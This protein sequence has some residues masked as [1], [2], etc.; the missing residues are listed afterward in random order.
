MNT[1]KVKKHNIYNAKWYH[2]VYIWFYN[3]FH[4]QKKSCT[5]QSWV[6]EIIWDNF[7]KGLSYPAINYELKD[8]KQF[9]ENF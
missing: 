2:F 6:Q 8:L 9:L 4:K 3:L 1:Y 7:E 5:K